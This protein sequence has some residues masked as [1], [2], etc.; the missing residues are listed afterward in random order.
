[1]INPLDK[2]VYKYLGFILLVIF[3]GLGSHGICNITMEKPA[4]F[5]GEGHFWNIFHPHQINSR[6]SKELQYEVRK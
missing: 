3:Y 5:V 4:P 6:K 1:M 2:V